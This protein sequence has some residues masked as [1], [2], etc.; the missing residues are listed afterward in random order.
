[1]TEAPTQQTRADED[2]RCLSVVMPCYNEARTVV[3]V[4]ERV[5]ESPFVA[6]VVV[7]DDGST[8]GTLDLVRTV[9]DDRVRVFQQPVNLGKG[10]ALRRGFQEAT[11]PFVIVQDA[12][13]EYDP[14]EYGEVLAPLIDGNGRRGLRLAVPRRRR[15]PGP[16]LL[17]LGRAT[18]SSRP[19]R[20]C[21][22][23]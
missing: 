19:R 11:A 15:A 6:E 12:D 1:M 23:T 10:A 20:T 5:L 9:D 13:L 3:E 14:A 21:S 7:V 16:L 2:Q 4:L 8:D 17:A 18:A 22:P